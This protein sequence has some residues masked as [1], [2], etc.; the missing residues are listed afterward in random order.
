M[1]SGLQLLDFGR[2]DKPDQ[3]FQCIFP[4]QNFGKS[5]IVKRAFQAKWFGKWRWL[6]YDHSRDLAF[7][8]TCITAIKMGRLTLSVGNVKDSAFVYPGFSNWKD[9]IA[10]F[11]SHEKSATH[12]RA[13]EG[14]ITLPKTTRDIGELISSAHAA[15]KRKNQ[16]C[17]VTI[18][19]NICFLARQGIALR[20]DGDESNSNF[21]Q[22]LHLRA[23]D[24]PQ[25]NT[26]LERKTDKYTSPQI[27]NEL[28]TVMATAVL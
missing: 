4:K 17:L 28:L 9:G 11:E 12:K 21:V 10:A 25:L 24:Q 14:V 15:E 8:R 19:K 6:H 2:D 23:I 13:V 27:Q 16:Q 26:W 20:G 5:K 22:L 1:T 3:P 7:C 18:A